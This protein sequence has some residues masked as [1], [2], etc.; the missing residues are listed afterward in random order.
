MT[1]GEAS[2]HASRTV[3]SAGP[4][5]T[6]APRRAWALE[7]H[8]TPRPRPVPDDRPWLVE[9]ERRMNARAPLGLI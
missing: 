6:A 9:L 3:H 8:A 1:A 5:T 7:Y 2:V 4:N